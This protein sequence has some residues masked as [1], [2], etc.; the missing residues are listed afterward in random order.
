MI[1]RASITRTDLLIET[2]DIFH[3]ITF[4]SNKFS[5]NLF[6]FYSLR[7]DGI[8]YPKRLEGDQTHPSRHVPVLG[9][10]FHV[11]REGPSSHNQSM[12]SGS[13]IHFILQFDGERPGGTHW[14]IRTGNIRRL[15][16]RDF[17]NF[18]I[19]CFQNVLV[20]Q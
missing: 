3:G 17:D 11:P 2:E 15:A 10:N 20:V 13:E 19:N 18:K 6:L 1:R 9:G 5:E 12:P 4:N 14:E 8:G 7:D 16:E